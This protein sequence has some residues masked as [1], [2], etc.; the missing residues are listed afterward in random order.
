ML[1]K[2]NEEDEFT[3]CVEEPVRTGVEEK[4]R[5]EFQNEKDRERRRRR[6]KN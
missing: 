3:Q 1:C 5:E 6:R 2:F 4:N